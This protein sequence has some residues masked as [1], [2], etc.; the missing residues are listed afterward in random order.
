MTQLDRGQI[1]AYRYR[2]TGLDEKLPAGEL[3][4]AARPGLQDSSPRSGVLSLHARAAGVASEDWSD[5]H[6]TQ[7]WGPRGAIYLIPKED[8]GVFTLGLLPRDG[9]RVATLSTQARRVIRMLDGRPQSTR[10]ILEA[11]PTLGSLR[12]LLWTATTG[13]FLPIW[14][15][16]ATAVYPAE[17][18]DADPEECR[19]E[20][21]R[22]F[23]HYLGPSTTKGLQWWTGSSDADAVA[24]MAALGPE[25]ATVTVD[26]EEVLMLAADVETAT[27]ASPPQGLHLL[28][29]DDP[30]INRLCGPLLVPDSGHYRLL[31][32]QAPLPGAIV[33][34]GVVV[35]VWRRRRRL[36]S[37]TLFPDISGGHLEDRIIEAAR[38]LP[39]PGD[40]EETVVDWDGDL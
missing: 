27:S 22:R 40:P 18:A 39:L 14:D 26:G 33:V 3:V 4:A 6:L 10:A 16:A 31:Y 24:T 21:G 12:E 35:G 23:L 15:A 34:D 25:L 29:P 11:I 28:A 13:W 8:L 17:P 20:L 1:L 32:P 9:E 7:V 5:G 2:A 37:I 30:Y 19:V 36:F 38:A